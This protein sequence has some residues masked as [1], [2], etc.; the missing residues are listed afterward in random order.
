VRPGPSREA[1]LPSTPRVLELP[2]LH[3]SNPGLYLQVNPA[4][5]QQRSRIVFS[6]LAG[7]GRQHRQLLAKWSRPI[8]LS[9]RSVL[10][11]MRRYRPVAAVIIRYDSLHVRDVSSLVRYEDAGG[12]EE[13]SN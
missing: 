2:T 11:R 10:A 13:S 9:A 12:S 4:H 8:W 1:A 6:V 5:Y 3:L 7:S